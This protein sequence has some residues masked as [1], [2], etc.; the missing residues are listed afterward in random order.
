MFEYL[1]P[2]LLQ[3]TFPNSLLDKAAARR[4]RSRTRTAAPARP[5]GNIR[6]RLR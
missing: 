6:V 2:L 4:W 1:M 3:R 5:V